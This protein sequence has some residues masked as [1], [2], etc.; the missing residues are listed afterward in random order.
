M[1]DGMTKEEVLYWFSK[2]PNL[3]KLDKKITI[4]IVDKLYNN[5]HID[6][7]VTLIMGSS[8]NAKALN[9]LTKN[10][11]RTLDTKNE[12]VLLPLISSFF[13]SSAETHLTDVMNH[14]KTMTEQ[15][16]NDKLFFVQTACELSIQICPSQISA[17]ILLAQFYDLTLKPQDALSTCERGLKQIE[18]IEGPLSFSR[19]ESMKLDLEDAK[20]VLMKLKQELNQELLFAQKYDLTIY[21]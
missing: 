19:H 20:D 18:E 7:F 5:P 9:D 16:I 12:Y 3:K 4:T 11:Y 17:Y 1:F 21:G 13:M 8:Q 14:L 6:I 10:Y 2:A 15:E